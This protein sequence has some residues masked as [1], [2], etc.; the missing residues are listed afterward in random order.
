MNEQRI[1]EELTALLEAN[2][3]T[4]RTEPLGGGGGGLCTIKD[5]SIFFVDTQA[6]SAEVSALAAEAIVKLIDT[7]SIYIK[8]EVRRI[9]DKYAKHIS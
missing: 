5:E 8:P 6:S 3:V 2:G 7:E 1:L 9:I 4:I